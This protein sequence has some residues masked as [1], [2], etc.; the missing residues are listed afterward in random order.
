MLLAKRSVT[1]ANQFIEASLKNKV[2]AKNGSFNG[3]SFWR[4]GKCC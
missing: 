3:K 4:Q 1:L 2:W